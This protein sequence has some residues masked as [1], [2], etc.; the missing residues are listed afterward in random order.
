MSPIQNVSIVNVVIDDIVVP[1]GYVVP[2][3]PVYNIN[4]N[5]NH[6]DIIDINS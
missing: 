1:A 5:I 3:I 6:H 4:N 2:V